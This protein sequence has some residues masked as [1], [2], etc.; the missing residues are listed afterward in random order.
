MRSYIAAVPL[1]FLLATVAEAEGQALSNAFAADKPVRSGAL[2]S[3]AESVV[4]APQGTNGFASK[5]SLRQRLS[6]YYPRFYNCFSGQWRN[7]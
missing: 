3:L 7:C 6:Q 4:S 5:R 2:S 1:A